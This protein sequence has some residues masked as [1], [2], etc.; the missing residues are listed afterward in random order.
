[1]SEASDKGKITTEISPDVISEALKSVEKHTGG[2]VEVEVDSSATAASEPVLAVESAE[3]A[4]APSAREAELEQE[5][6]QLQ[7]Q[8]E[9]S[10][11]KG[12]ELMEKI[13][14]AHEK[15]L[16]AVADLDNF[17]KRAAKEREEVQRFGSEKLLKDFLPVIDNLERALSHAEQGADF[18]GLKTGVAMT[19]KLFEDAVGKHGMKGFTSAA[20]PFDP[21][22]HEAMQQA[23][24]DAMPPNH[25]FHEV[26]RGYTLHDRLIRPAL[27]VVS[28]AK[29]AVA[30]VAQEPKAAAPTS[31]TAAAGDRPPE[32]VQASSATED[33]DP[34]GSATKDS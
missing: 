16:R 24:T 30:P 22:R 6:A 13:K 7:A 20:Q 2:D 4:A 25:V 27:V 15:M 31:Q 21:H 10:Q 34:A 33:I 3:E 1:M 28:K 8:L 29:P 12:R 32:D 5:V 23:E 14:D 26:L 11:A 18:A 19:K 17:K 9:F